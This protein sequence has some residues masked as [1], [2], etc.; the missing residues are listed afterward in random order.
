MTEGNA[1]YSATPLRSNPSDRFIGNEVFDY[2]SIQLSDNDI[3]SQEFAIVSDAF[4]GQNPDPTQKKFR[5]LY[6]D[7]NSWVDLSSSFVRTRFKIGQQGTTNINVAHGA[8]TIPDIRSLWEQVIFSLGG[9]EI[10]N[11][12][13]DFWAYAQLSNKFYTDKFINKVGNQMG[14]YKMRDGQPGFE[15]FRSQS[16]DIARRDPVNLH[17]IAITDPA[18][19][20]VVPIPLTTCMNFSNNGEGQLGTLESDVPRLTAGVTNWTGSVI[21]FWTPL[22]TLLNFAQGFPRCIK[23][24]KV[25]LDLYKASD[26]ISIYTPDLG[27][28]PYAPPNTNAAFVGW[29]R[30][31]VQLYVRRIRAN[32]EIERS[33]TARLASGINYKATFEDHYLDRFHFTPQDLKVEHRIV[34][35]GSLPTKVWCAFQLTDTLTNQSLP[36]FNFIFPNL[37][38]IQLY[39]N[40]QLVPQNQIV[41]NAVEPTQ[42][43]PAEQVNNLDDLQIPYQQYLDMCGVVQNSSPMLRN[44]RGGSGS[45]TYSQ[46]RSSCPLFCWDL[47]NI[48]MTPFFEGRAEIVIR[49]TK[50]ETPLQNPPEPVNGYEMFTIVHCLKTAELSFKEHASYITMNAPSP[51]P[52]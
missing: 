7:L 20:A 36:S 24:L 44:F 47:S 23:G 18:G 49:F 40:G 38:D 27:N 25:Q 52:P 14:L 50:I 12:S 46:W 1:L 42:L 22:S 51:P 48:S 15:T 9:T 13:K 6:E 30:Q 45:L 41:M 16:Y 37:T 26:R 4:Q 21:D 31:G 19:T 28:G 11:H 2:S 34:N 5:F 10:E 32:E 3:Y 33:L 39:V 35:V 8:A 17:Y 43:M 29:E